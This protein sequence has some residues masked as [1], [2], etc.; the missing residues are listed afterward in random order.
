MIAHTT[1]VIPVLESEDK[2]S[3]WGLLANKPR[4]TGELEAISNNQIENVR[5]VDVI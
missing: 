2:E 3:L 4:W 5:K 1:S